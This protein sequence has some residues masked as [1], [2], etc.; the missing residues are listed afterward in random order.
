MSNQPDRDSNCHAKEKEDQLELWASPSSSTK[1]KI[2]D[3]G[4]YTAL[5]KSKFLIILKFLNN[6]TEKKK[7]QLLLHSSGFQISTETLRHIFEQLPQS[8]LQSVWSI[9]ESPIQFL[10]ITLPHPEFS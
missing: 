8:H 2:P 5:A 7:T 6:S 9:F 4:F 10:P 1:M 3:W